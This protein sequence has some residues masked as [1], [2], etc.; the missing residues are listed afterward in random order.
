MKYSIEGKYSG[1][2]AFVNID[3]DSVELTVYEETSTGKNVAVGKSF[4]NTRTAQPYGQ[5]G[6]RYAVSSGRVPTA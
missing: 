5:G 2:E 3:N 4:V 1:Q 6:E